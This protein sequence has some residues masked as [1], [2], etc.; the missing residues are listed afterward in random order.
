MT[1][2]IGLSWTQM[3]RT[4]L[5]RIRAYLAGG[6]LVPPLAH[7]GGTWRPKS[8]APFFEDA[9]AAGADTGTG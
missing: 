1:F 7:R 8:I 5:Q 6:P 2:Y 4:D 9:P 3:P